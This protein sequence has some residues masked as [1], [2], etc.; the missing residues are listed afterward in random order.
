M[1]TKNNRRQKYTGGYNNNNKQKYTGGY[2]NNN[3]SNFYMERKGESR[4]TLL[5]FQGGEY[6]S[7]GPGPPQVPACFDINYSVKS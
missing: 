5:R 6:K 4:D 7:L 1:E 3:K 2:N